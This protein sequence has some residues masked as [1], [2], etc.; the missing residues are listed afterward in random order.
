MFGDAY[1][2]ASTGFLNELKCSQYVECSYYIQVITTK[3][4]TTKSKYPTANGIINTNNL[5][6]LTDI[7]NF[8][9]LSVY[10]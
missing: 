2:E 9:S 6:F 3:Q 4:L 5:E 10:H 7:T 1:L 8:A